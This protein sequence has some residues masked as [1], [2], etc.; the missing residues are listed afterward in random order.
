MFVGSLVRITENTPRRKQHL[1]I[2]LKANCFPTG[3]LASYTVQFLR[4]TPEGK[5][6]TNSF[7]P[8]QLEVVN[9]SR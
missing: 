4:E 3:K 7:A 5:A 6:Y 2:V 8:Y 9:E 1:G